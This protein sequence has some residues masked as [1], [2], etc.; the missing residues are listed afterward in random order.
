M[1]STLEIHENAVKPDAIYEMALGFAVTKTLVTARR[2]GLFEA[3]SDAEKSAEELAQEK[4]L[5][6]YPTEMLLN[7]CV[8]LKLCRKTEGRYSNTPLAQR[9]LTRGGGH[10]LGRFLDHFNDHMVPAWTYLEDAV[11]TGHAQ[12][13]R[14]VGDKNDHF[15]QA[16]DKGAN[17][18]EVFMETMEQHSLLEGEALART[19]DFEAHHELLD[20]GG[21]TGAM[22][23]A[24]V[25]AHPHLRAIVFDRPPVCAIAKRKI[26]E[27]GLA[28]QIHAQP[29][30]FFKDPLPRRAD[31][32][33]LSGILHN[34]SPV[35]AK[36]ILC[37]CAQALP[38]GGTLLIS[39]QLL[40]ADKTGPLP[41]ALCSL[42]MLVMMEGG[43]EYNEAEYADFLVHSG[44]QLLETRSTG[45]L[46][47][48]L[49][50]R[51]T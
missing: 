7:T 10:D 13:Q 26:Q 6:A 40:N 18:L 33:L 3:L 11:R 14:L 5:A 25:R 21:G 20:V 2:L 1:T 43:Q 23:V 51:R 39:E 46:R 38:V 8:T 48:L 50:A 24:I 34:W 44:F 12:I 4:G 28:D 9:F 45:G 15:F 19:Y 32:L 16:I 27:H 47:Q 41:A 37:R 49:I 29:G 36:A 42:N 22:D 35:N 17:D 30:D 31:V